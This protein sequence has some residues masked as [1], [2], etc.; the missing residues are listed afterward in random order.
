MEQLD[1]GDDGEINMLLRPD[2]VTLG[3]L[4]EWP[5]YGA[6]YTPD[7]MADYL[8]AAVET[9]D[10]V[11]ASGDS[12]PVSEEVIE[13][14]AIGFVYQSLEEVNEVITRANRRHYEQPSAEASTVM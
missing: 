5:K 8:L 12:L 14:L 2:R 11:D 9:W 13:S 6:G 4:R 7:M 3:T 1:L 10:L